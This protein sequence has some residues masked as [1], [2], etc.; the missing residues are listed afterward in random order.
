MNLYFIFFSLSLSFSFSLPFLNEYHTYKQASVKISPKA[1]MTIHES[2]KLCWFSSF[3]LSLSP[4]SNCITCSVSYTNRAQLRPDTLQQALL[5][6]VVDLF[7]LYWNTKNF[8]YFGVVAENN[9]T[10]YRKTCENASYLR[11]ILINYWPI[12]NNLAPAICFLNARTIREGT[13]TINLF[14]RVYIYIYEF[15]RKIY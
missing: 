6:Y 1:V 7:L 9:T 12:S 13:R 14:M 5:K 8:F 4:S 10:D 3:F 2:F 15:S 11:F